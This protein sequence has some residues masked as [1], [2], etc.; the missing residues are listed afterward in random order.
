LHLALGDTEIHAVD[1][2]EPRSRFQTPATLKKMVKKAA[3]RP[4]RKPA[5]KRTAKRAWKR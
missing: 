1:D 3:K 2:A 4:T 5:S